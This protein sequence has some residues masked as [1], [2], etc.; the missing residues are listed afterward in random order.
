[1]VV[2]LSR[3]FGAAP[4]PPTMLHARRGTVHFLERRPERFSER[5]LD[6]AWANRSRSTG[7][8]GAGDVTKE[9][10]EDQEGDACLV[11]PEDKPPPVMKH[12]WM[13]GS[14]DDSQ[15][16]FEHSTCSYQRAIFSLLLR[17]E[18][19]GRPRLLRE[20]APIRPLLVV[21]VSAVD[22]STPISHYVECT[23]VVRCLCRPI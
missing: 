18:T 16:C 5:R 10:D 23:A 1:M 20:Y 6:G 13:R 17:R 3:L 19:T 14:I 15:V 2:F 22:R 7:F 21:A 9:E 12:Q 8:N 4:R 11:E